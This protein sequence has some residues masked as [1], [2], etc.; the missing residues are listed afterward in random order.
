MS[1]EYLQADVAKIGSL[2]ANHTTLH[3]LSITSTLTAADIVSTG[4]IHAYNTCTADTFSGLNINSNHA[5]LGTLGLGDGFSNP[6]SGIA[7]SG[8]PGVAV[9]TMK[10]DGYRIG[11]VVTLA[12][13]QHGVFTNPAPNIPAGQYLRSQTG[14]EIPVNFRP[15]TSCIFP[16]SGR[17]FR[18]VDY[19]FVLMSMT[20]YPDGTWDLK[21]I[22]PTISPSGSNYFLAL[23]SPI[24]YTVV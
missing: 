23:P 4:N 12:L 2:T 8:S 22:D 5:V 3:D 24:S 7:M 14:S 13:T 6:S 11:N 20:I 18:G 10:M 15:A 1:F 19:E 9:L 16:V 17:F 21:S